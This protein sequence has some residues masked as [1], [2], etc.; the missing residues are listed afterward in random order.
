MI[1]ATEK[2]DL[3]SPELSKPTTTEHF[4]D[5]KIYRYSIFK[6]AL[7]IFKLLKLKFHFCAQILDSDRI[8]ISM[9]HTMNAE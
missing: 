1:S 2:K 4:L 9:K 3:H 5:Q 6:Y 7:R 8:F